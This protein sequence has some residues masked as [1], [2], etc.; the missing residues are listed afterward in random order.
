MR[1]NEIIKIKITDVTIDGSGI[2][3]HEGMAVFVPCSAIGDELEVKI[4]KVKS[5]YSFGRIEKIISPGYDRIQHD[6]IAY[7]KCGGCTFRHISYDAEL[8]IKEK[9]VKD[10]ITRIGEQDNIKISEIIG[11]SKTEYYRNKMQLPIRKGRQGEIR[12]G[13]YRAYS[14]DIV[15]SDKCKLHPKIFEDIVKTIKEWMIEKNIE[16]YDELD[17]SGTVRHIYLRQAEKSQEIL[18][19]IVI[20]SDD[21][22]FKNDLVNCIT[23]KYKDIIG[24]VLNI[25]KNDTNVVLGEKEKVI[26]GRNYIKDMLCGLKL[27]ISAKSF[28][29]V[30]HRQ[31]EILYET[32]REVLE[33]TGKERILELY[34]GIGAIGL[35]LSRFAF[36][37]VGVEIVQEAVEN[38][39]L[40]AQMNGCDNI[41]FICG[42]SSKKFSE[43]LMELSDIDIIVIDPPRQGCEKE[44]IS[45]ISEID[46]NKVVYISCN[47]STLARDIKEFCKYNF[48]VEKVCPAD[49]FPRSAHVETVVLMSKVDR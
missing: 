14:H 41:K 5:N 25:N 23:N 22:R 42:D 31:T 45:K 15:E 9:Y 39:K 43:A 18:L 34:C 6:C 26:Y 3:R 12:V 36:S 27:N 16:P 44:L 32:V 29:Q 35:F 19:C 47:P 40:N 24:I 8:K 49:M 10:C 38:A 46:A 37:V 7:P 28:Y 33:L 11:C 21:L 1:K 48:E 13:F 30:N 17:K 4:V 2:G 20:N